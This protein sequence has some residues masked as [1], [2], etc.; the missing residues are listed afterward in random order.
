MLATNAP[1]QSRIP[2]V[3][4]KVIGELAK[5]IRPVIRFAR[6]RQKI[7]NGK[8]VE[9]LDPNGKLQRDD[10]G[11]LYFIKPVNPFNIAFPWDPKP[12][13]RAPRLQELCKITTYHTWAYYGCF[14]PTI[15]EVLAQIPAEHL[16]KTIAFSTQ[17][18]ETAADLNR[19]IEITNEGYHV[20]ETTLYI[21][22]PWR[23]K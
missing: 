21:R 3:P 17:G 15:A 11:S 14:K 4:Q 22:R 23:K 18:P 2:E 8:I 7:R 10:R 19:H 1:K 12:D 20:A 9:V 13:T 16:D 5:R 6:V